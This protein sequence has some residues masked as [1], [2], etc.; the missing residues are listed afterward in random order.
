VLR[1]GMHGMAG[2]LRIALAAALSFTSSLVVQVQ[3]SLLLVAATAVGHST[4][5]P[6]HVPFLMHTTV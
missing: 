3:T 5:E 1:L 6:K 4:A 2:T